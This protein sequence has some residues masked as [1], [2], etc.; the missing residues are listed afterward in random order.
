MLID[1]EFAEI[2]QKNTFNNSENVLKRLESINRLETH[3]TGRE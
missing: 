1:N 2:K 3:L